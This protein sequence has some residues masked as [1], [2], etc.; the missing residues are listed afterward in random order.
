MKA[1]NNADQDAWVREAAASYEQPLL[2]YVRGL[3]GDAERSREV[4]QDAFC[5]LC[6][7]SRAELDGRLAAWLYT[8]CRHRA[9]DV[10]RKEKRM[11]TITDTGLSGDI[12]G[13]INGGNVSQ[14]AADDPV[15]RVVK[16]E[17]VSRVMDLV[18]QLPTDQREVIRLRFQGQL[19]YK[20]IS[21]VTG[22]SVSNVGFLLHRA[23]RTIRG[24]MEEQDTSVGKTTAG[25]RDSSEGET[26]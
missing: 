22:H 25:L 13:I 17:S 14:S 24:T 3:L 8:V 16:R 7:Q 9:L 18:E 23:I 2:L 15:E 1:S 26:Q 11:N 20:Q 12:A 19:S 21:E 6:E 4:V 10:L 5:R